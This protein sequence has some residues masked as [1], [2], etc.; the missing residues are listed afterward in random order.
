MTASNVSFDGTGAV[1]LNAPLTADTIINADIKPDAAIADTKLATISTAGKVNNSATTAT[2]A[3]TRSAIIARDASG[4]F[5]GGTFTGEVNRDAQTT[6]T[7]GTYGSATA[8][9]VL[10]IDANGFVDSA[11]TIGVSGITGVDFDSSNGTLTIATS[12]DDFT[13]V[14]TLDPF[15]TANL[16]E[17]TN[18]YYTDARAR[19]SISGN[20]GLAYNS[21]T[22][23]M[24]LDS[25]NV[26]GMFSASGQLAYNSGTGAFTFTNRS[27][28]DTLTAIKAVD[29]ASSG[30]DADL[31]D[32]QE[33]SHYRINV[34][35]NSGT[36]LN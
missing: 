23:V 19:A 5:A 34:Y 9:P 1:T 25:A 10:T 27:N 24:D 26:R 18:L 36:L 6:V 30:L 8:I 32:G 13:D 7:A 2:A 28:A 4:N 15:T 16:S 35:N 31:L 11:G 14:I 17:N 22:G 20:K 3:N 21:S 12:G 33:G 29:G